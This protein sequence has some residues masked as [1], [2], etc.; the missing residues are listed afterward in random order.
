MY[1]CSSGERYD[2]SR[3]IIDTP[4]RS[5]L[6]QAQTPQAFSL[7]LI[8]ECYRRAL[9]EEA[10]GLTDDASCVEYCKKGS[11]HRTEC[12]YDILKITTP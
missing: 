6:W 9:E 2:K 5:R 7:S 10:A 3:N 4:D 8:R 12:S 1:C 11:V